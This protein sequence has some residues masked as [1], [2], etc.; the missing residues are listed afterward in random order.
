MLKDVL[1]VFK[2]YLGFYIFF[3]VPDG[4]HMIDVNHGW[5]RSYKPQ[6]LGFVTS[7]ILT[8]AAYRMVTYYELT[9]FLLTL[10]VFGLAILQ[11]LVQLFFFLHLGLEPKPHWGMITFLCTMLVI[12]VV[13]GGSL[14]IM[15]N[16]DYNLMPMMK[17]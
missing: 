15:N 6:F 13:I 9:D 10:T 3:S 17:H 4:G 12:V 1:A 16:L 11:A 5:N 8:L 2:Y 14:W 7:L